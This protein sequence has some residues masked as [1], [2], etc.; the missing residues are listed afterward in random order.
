[1]LEYDGDVDHNVLRL[2]EHHARATGLSLAMLDLLG[3]NAR[4]AFAF[5]EAAEDGDV[6]AFIEATDWQ[7][8]EAKAG[9]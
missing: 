7:A 2:L 9:W 8:L 4:A 3:T 1:M 5:I 6:T